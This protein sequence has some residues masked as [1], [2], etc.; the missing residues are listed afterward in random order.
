MFTYLT[1][2]ARD[3]NKI[4]SI[5]RNTFPRF[6]YFYIW[7]GRALHHALI[8]STWCLKHTECLQVLFTWYFDS[9]TLVLDI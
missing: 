6:H 3:S 9:L 5:Y 4:R 7:P 8:H 2:A 1:Y